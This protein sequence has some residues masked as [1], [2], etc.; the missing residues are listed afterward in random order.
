MDEKFDKTVDDIIEQI[1]VLGDRPSER[2]EH[3]E[4]GSELEEERAQEAYEEIRE[5]SA[6]SF[7]GFE[8]TSST[9]N[10]ESESLIIGKVSNI[11]RSFETLH[12]SSETESKEKLGK[13]IETRKRYRTRTVT[14][15]GDSSPFMTFEPKRRKVLTEVRKFENM[16]NVDIPSAKR[17]NPRGKK[18][19]CRR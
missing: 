9:P 12:I 8:P 16:A 3:I 14:K 19:G 15:K 18:T 5:S 11:I 4:S 10:R 1:G 7:E 17:L 13:Q 6:N 2:V